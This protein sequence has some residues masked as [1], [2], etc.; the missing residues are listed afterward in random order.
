MAVV[1]FLLGMRPA[2][3]RRNRLAP[4][5]I[6]GSDGARPSGLELAPLRVARVCAPM[7]QR[8]KVLIID[9]DPDVRKIAH[10]CLTQLGGM[11][12]VEASNAAD[13]VAT[14]ASE[15]PDAILL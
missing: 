3:F 1:T 8:L 14:A 6:G 12:V 9:D 7:G 13:G 2:V 4:N 11:D 15:K 5:D 10:L